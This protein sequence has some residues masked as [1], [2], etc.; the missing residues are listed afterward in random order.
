MHLV[1]SSSYWCIWDNAYCCML[2]LCFLFYQFL[3]I[4]NL[5]YFSLELHPLFV[6]SSFFRERHSK[7]YITIWFNKIFW[8][9]FSRNTKQIWHTKIFQ[10]SKLIMYM[11]KQGQKIRWVP[12][13]KHKNIYL[14]IKL[15]LYQFN[16]SIFKTSSGVGFFDTP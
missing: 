8:E 7:L 9:K 16:N 2:Y 3:F 10:S 15:I 4:I 11:R 14:Y 6:V 1:N 13:I 12:I 5:F